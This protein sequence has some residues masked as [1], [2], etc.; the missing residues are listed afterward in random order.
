MLYFGERGSQFFA[1]AGLFD[2]SINYDG[3]TLGAVRPFV[4]L[5]VFNLFNN[6]KVI[7]FDTTVVPD[8]ASPRDALGLPTGFIR[9]P[10]FGQPDSAGD[11]PAP[12]TGLTGGRSARVAVGIRF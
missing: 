7:R 8:E 11:F 3:P 12:T 4:K 2:V 5:D 6:Q 9:S 10:R 1:G